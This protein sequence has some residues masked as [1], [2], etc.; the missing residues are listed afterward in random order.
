MFHLG[1]SQEML[2]QV[3]NQPHQGVASDGFD[4]TIVVHWLHPESAILVDSIVTK[5]M[6]VPDSDFRKIQEVAPQLAI[7][8]SNALPA[9]TIHCQSPILELLPIVAESFGAKVTGHMD[10]DAAWVYEGPWDGRSI[11]VLTDSAVSTLF[12]AFSSP[13]PNKCELAWSLDRERYLDWFNKHLASS[14]QASLAIAPIQALIT[15]QKALLEELFPNGWFTGAIHERSQHPANIRWRACEDLLAQKGRVRLS[16]AVEVV[17][18]FLSTWL[19]NFALIQATQ[20]SVV[21]QRVGDLAN[22]GDK[23]VQK[24]LRAVVRDPDQFFDVLLEVSCAAWHIS[25][26]HKVEATQRDGMPDLALEIP[27]WQLPIQA[28]CKRVKRSSRIK[29]AIEKA[30]RQIKNV[31]QRCYGLVYIDVSECAKVPDL[32]DPL[33]LRDDKIPDEIVA[34]K[35]EVQRLL[36][37]VYT[38]VSGVILLWKHHIVLPMKDGGLLFIFRYQNLLV[39]HRSPK[40][41]LPEDTEQISVGYTNTVRILPDA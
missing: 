11:H 23:A 30:N 12:V 35:N 40:E 19:D 5:Y 17:K 28:E 36:D 20:G 39:R 38:S 14:V 41:P 21:S 3:V 26:G 9:G 18:L 24:R 13:A 6:D 34:I 29:E 33:S 16:G 25:H 8:I 4:R 7:R 2:T 22:Y 37:R 27:G 10:E 15:A 32:V 1:I 31:G